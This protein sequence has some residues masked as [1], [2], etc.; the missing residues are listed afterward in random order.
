MGPDGSVRCHWLQVRKAQLIKAN[1][2]KL[3]PTVFK[4]ELFEV[5]LFKLKSW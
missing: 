5:N 2:V 3:A 1:A 4:K